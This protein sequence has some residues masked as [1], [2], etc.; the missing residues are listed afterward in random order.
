MGSF[1]ASANNRKIK[2][3][4]VNFSLCLLNS[5]ANLSLNLV[6]ILNSDV[7]SSFCFGL[8]SFL[9]NLC[10]GWDSERT[11]MNACVKEKRTCA[12]IGIL[13]PYFSPF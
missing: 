13:K 5:D 10:F 8:F 7:N 6:F 4:N 12:A 3:D 11:A 1:E 2:F 9:N